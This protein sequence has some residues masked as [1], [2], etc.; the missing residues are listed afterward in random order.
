MTSYKIAVATSDG[1]HVD[2]HF[3]RCRRFTI[4]TVQQESGQWQ[5]EEV[6]DVPPSSEPSPGHDPAYLALVAEL[7]G[8]C[9]Y[10]MTSKIG[11]RPSGVLQRYGISVLQISMPIEPA[12]DKLN[13]Y[14]LAL[15]RRTKNRMER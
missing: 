15:A 14:R 1:T 3:G 10:L 4:I 12:V 2:Q 7:L 11:P 6:R 8:D 13:E 9:S 5:V